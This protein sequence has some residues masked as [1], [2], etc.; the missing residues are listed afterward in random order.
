[1]V[2]GADTRLPRESARGRPVRDAMRL[3]PKTLA[4]DVT[5]GEVRAFFAGSSARLALLVDGGKFVAALTRDEIPAAA[6]DGL[7]AA[8]FGRPDIDWVGPE[9]LTDEIVEALEAAPERRLVVL[10][11]DRTLA[12]LLCLNRSGTEFC[13]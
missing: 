12:G 7:P 1:M 8:D 4:A 9:V 6:D 2:R 11:R 13:R 5:V 10:E 3:D